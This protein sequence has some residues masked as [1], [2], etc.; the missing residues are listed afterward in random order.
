[1][2]SS[3]TY[4]PF[5]NEDTD[6]YVLSIKDDEDNTLSQDT[7]Q[8]SSLPIN[9]SQ[10]SS[11]AMDTSKSSSSSKEAPWCSCSCNICVQE[12]FPLTE[13][14]ASPPKEVKEDDRFS[15]DDNN[16]NL[17]EEEDCSYMNVPQNNFPLDSETSEGE[18]VG[19]SGIMGAP[20]VKRKFP[21]Y[22]NI[23]ALGAD[24]HD[25]HV[26]VAQL[27]CLD[28]N[29]PAPATEPP[30]SYLDFPLQPPPLPPKSYRV[31]LL[32]IFDGNSSQNNVATNFPRR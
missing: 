1:M 7:S 21:S 3:V 26:P 32:S 30:R 23:T 27:I 10:A 16:T 6:E 2:G 11:S 20:L 19:T 22:V 15:E 14:C 24:V 13:T 17:A 4:V 8:P 25:A 5:H 31:E 9:T 28:S 12:P 29:A 18:V